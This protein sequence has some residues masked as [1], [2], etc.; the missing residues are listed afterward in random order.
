MAFQLDQIRRLFRQLLIYRSLPEDPAIRPLFGPDAEPILAGWFGSLLERYP[1]SGNPWASLLR[2]AI[3][4]NENYFSLAA[5]RRA[6]ASLSRSITEAVRHDLTVI[7]ALFRCRPEPGIDLPTPSLPAGTDA[8]IELLASGR[9]E[10]AYRWLAA[11][12][13]RH[14]VGI[15]G[16]Q[17]FFIW[18]PLT[19]RIKA[20][21]NPD[22]V[23]VTDL[24]GYESQKE[25]LIKNTQKLLNGLPANNV[26]L[27]GDRGTGKSSLVKAVANQFRE[28]GLRLIEVNK[29]D[30]TDFPDL[31]GRLSDRGLSFIIYVDDLSFEVGESQ[32]K[33][34]KA[35]L[36]GSLSTRPRNLLIYA[37]SNRRHL[38]RETMAE[39]DEDVHFND[40]MQEKLSLA[41]RFG[42]TITFLAP[43]QE[44]Y[45]SI[46]RGL[47]RQRGLD[48]PAPALEAKALRWERVQNGRSGRTARQFVDDLQGELIL[49]APDRKATD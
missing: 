29:T 38:I 43:D 8:E 47:A 12:Y 6:V 49:A 18:D 22:P 11:Y 30:L 3:V 16:Q 10:E 25:T 35:V 33:H 2:D 9:A 32:Y 28:N 7:A 20:V 40:A 36:E 26:L 5:E 4:N 17:A 27:Y 48:I 13:Q 37:T 31:V 14:G 19:K 34:L 1:D 15:F 45:L 39:R 44:E 42:V 21:A 41:D 46:V 24:I 23:T